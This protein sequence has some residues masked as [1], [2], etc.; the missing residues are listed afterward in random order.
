MVHGTKTARA[1]CGRLFVRQVGKLDR[2]EVRNARSF[3]D[4]S[5]WE[6]RDIKDIE[7]LKRL[8]RE[9]LKYSS[10]QSYEDPMLRAAAIDPSGQRRVIVIN[11]GVDRGDPDPM[12]C[13][14]ECGRR[15]CRRLRRLSRH[16][17]GLPSA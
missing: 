16:S 6:S 9:G 3:Y 7:T 13:T 10:A 12:Y 8:M 4:R 15:H 11:T 5:I 2:P 17:A 1:P 14:R